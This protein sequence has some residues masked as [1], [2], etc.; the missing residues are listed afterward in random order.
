MQ[1]A[2]LSAVARLRRQPGINPGPV[3]V[4][5][6]SM[7]A[8][9]A[10]VLSAAQPEDIAAAVVFYGTY[11]KWISNGR[12]LHSRATLPKMMSLNR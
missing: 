4:I 12:K 7:G 5:G 1:T 9:W 11:D 2:A 8:A 6:F 10:L 3:G